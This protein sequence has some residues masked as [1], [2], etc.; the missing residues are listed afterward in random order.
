M[1]A[2]LPGSRI[3]SSAALLIVLV[4]LAGC[5]KK[6]PPVQPGPADKIIYPHSYPQF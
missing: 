2:G 1:S 6:G 5:G 3:A 4:L